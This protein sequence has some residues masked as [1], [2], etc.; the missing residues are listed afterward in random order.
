MW[1]ELKQQ[2][3]LNNNINIIIII[4]IVIITIVIITG[5]Q[6]G[7]EHREYDSRLQFTSITRKRSGT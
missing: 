1:G 7:S 5:I 4:T 2:A 6:R 3:K